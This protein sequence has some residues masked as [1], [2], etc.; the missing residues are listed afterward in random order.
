MDAVLPAAVIV[1][2]DRLAAL[3]SLLRAFVLG[4]AIIHAGI[5]GKRLVAHQTVNAARIRHRRGA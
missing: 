5:R 2:V 1:A 4:Q 3:P